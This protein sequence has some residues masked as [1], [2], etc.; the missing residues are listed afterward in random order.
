MLRSLGVRDEDVELGALARPDARGGCDVH[1]GIADRGR[2]LRQR[3]RVFSM[4]MTR[5]T[6]IC[7][8]PAPAYWS[9]S[10]LTCR[11]EPISATVE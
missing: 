2:D 4:S 11:G 8:R 6:A 10:E 5:S 7:P 9:S 3:P 1:A